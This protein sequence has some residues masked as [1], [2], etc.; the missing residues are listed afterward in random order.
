MS[1]VEHVLR[2]RWLLW[3]AGAAFALSLMIRR[4][5]APDAGAPWPRLPRLPLPGF[6]LALSLLCTAFFGLALLEKVSQLEAHALNSQDFWL[7]VDMIRQTSRGAPFLTRFAP[8]DTGWIQHGA[9]HPFFALCLAVPLAWLTSSTW[10]ALALMP[11]ALSLAAAVLALWARQLVGARNALLAA[12]A[13]LLSN[14]VGKVLSYETHPEALYPLA[15]FLWAWGSGFGTGG[16]VRWTWAILGASLGAA[17]KEDAFLV[18]LPLMSCQLLSSLR[19]KRDPARLAVASV[20]LLLVLFGAVFQFLAVSRFGSGAWGP[21]LWEGQP[22]RLPAGPAAFQ[23]HRWD[24]VSSAWEILAAYR[25]QSGGLIGLG[26]RA[27]VFW[28]S[29]PWISLLALSPW[30]LIQPGFVLSVVPLSLTHAW[31]GGIPAQ[32]N[33]YYSAPFLGLFWI[34]AIRGLGMP[35]DPRRLAWLVAATLLVG[36]GGLELWVSSRVARDLDDMTQPLLACL[37][38]KSRGIVSPALI[39]N[40]PESQI[41]LDRVPVRPEDWSDLSFALLTPGVPRFEMP[42]TEL[43]RARA[44]LQHKPGWRRV[45]PD[46]RRESASSLPTKTPA[47]ELWMRTDSLRESP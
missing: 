22:V 19:A 35:A 43:A 24:S 2:L 5:R 7:F 14:Q 17:I 29:R 8:Q 31:I 33:L 18:F 39:G 44:E 23:G 11:L 20:G 40:V 30:V 9:V 25:A 28:V 45:D 38:P 36:S 6:A 4:L 32:L 12:A 47:V 34:H 15:V 37:H 42:A 27:A 46:C 26:A 13:F 41:L 1:T 10:A 3:G 21:R 16:R